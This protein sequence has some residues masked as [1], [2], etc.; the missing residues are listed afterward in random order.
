MPKIERDL[1]RG[2]GLEI[3][4]G[5]H[6]L[7]SDDPFMDSFLLSLDQI[8]AIIFSISFLASDQR[9]RD[10]RP[11]HFCIFFI[12]VLPTFLLSSTQLFL[13]V[14]GKSLTNYD[15]IDGQS[16]RSNNSF[17]AWIFDI[18]WFHKMALQNYLPLPFLLACLIFGTMTIMAGR[19]KYRV[20]GWEISTFLIS[21]VPAVF[22]FFL[23]RNLNPNL[24]NF[25]LR[26][27][28]SSSLEEKIVNYVRNEWI[29]TYKDFT[30]C[31]ES[32]HFS[33]MFVRQWWAQN[34]RGLLPLT[35][36]PSFSVAIIIFSQRILKK[37][38]T[39]KRGRCLMSKNIFKLLVWSLMLVSTLICWSVFIYYSEELLFSRPTT[40][41]V[42]SNIS[43]ARKLLRRNVYEFEST[44]IPCLKKILRPNGTVIGLS[45][46]LMMPKEILVHKYKEIVGGQDFKML[47][48]DFQA[49]EI[50]N[51]FY[52]WNLYPPL[53]L[54]FF[55]AAVTV[56]SVPVS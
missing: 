8:M 25:F 34:R 55:I 19:N 13:T 41:I 33:T 7:L 43:L 29:I 16:S 30:Y 40:L 37:I 35:I 45:H 11:F 9:I 2:T 21:L 38:C 15:I 42:P 17:R 24:I 22:Y 52:V 47:M 6:N 44:F 32:N 14:H 27:N 39:L 49:A 28:E 31:M 50:F 5:N 54:L 48:K 26:Q 4:V 18:Q 53:L 46:P 20:C 23:Y 10:K 12:I 1:R 51:R 56:K 36:A 3:R